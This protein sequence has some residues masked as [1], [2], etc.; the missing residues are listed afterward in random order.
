MK[1]IVSILLALILSFALVACAD[2]EAPQPDAPAA[3]EEQAPITPTAAKINGVDISEYTIVYAYNPDRAFYAQ[4]PELVTQ[5]TEY[6]KQTAENL[7]ALIKTNFGATV[8]VARDEEQAKG[9]KEIIIGMTNRGLV[10]VTLGSFTSVKDYAVKEN[11]GKIVI[12]GKSYGATWHAA[13]DFIADLLTQNAAV[14]EVKAGYSLSAKAKMVVVGCIGDSITNGSGSKGTT[15]TDNSTRRAIVS[16][17][18]VLQ[19]I[20]WKD[21]VVY[22][23][24][25]GGRTMIENFVWT[26]GSGN[27]GWT[28]STY[29]QP[30]MDNAA[31]I[32]LALIMLGTNDS[33]S[34]RAKDAGYN[35]GTT[36]YKNTF[37]NSCEKIVNELKAKNSNMEIALLNCPVSY[38]SFEADMMLYI[39]PYQKAAAQKLGLHHLD[40]Y[41]ETMNKTTSTDYPDGLHPSDTGYTKYAQIVDGLIAPIV[42]DILAK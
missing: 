7:A 34:S 29:Y 26:D 41:K 33:N 38:H 37:I 16:Y 35:F 6:D 27:H 15:I 36:A 10:D 19:R 11:G 2:S 20:E 25:Q 18:A 9:D 22:N 14:A 17:P 13:E 40:M 28:S 39:R 4:Y 42:K 31:N 23:Y 8:K 24:G 30:C 21:M 12:C 5:D 1:K 3:E 32:D